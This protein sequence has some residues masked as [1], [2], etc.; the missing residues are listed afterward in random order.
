MAARNGALA[1]LIDVTAG[2]GEAG[3]AQGAIAEI[4]T[5]ENP[6]L[7][8]MTWK[9]GNLLTGERT[10]VRT[11]KPGVAWRRYNQ[12]VPVS[13]GTAGSIDEGAAQLAATSQMDRS[14]AILGGNPARARMSFAKP[15]FEAMNDEA[16]LKLFY[17]NATFESK[18]FTGLTPRFNSLS[19]PTASQ[20]L[21]CLGTGTDNRSM[22]LID[23]DEE[24]ITGIY[25]KGTKA[26]LLHMDST[27]N[28][29]SGPDGYPIGD[30]TPDASGNQYLAYT[31]FFQ[32]DLG[33]AVKDPRHVVRA[34]NIDFSLMAKD[35]STGADLEDILVQMFHRANRIGPNAAF[36]VPKPVG[37]ML[38]RQALSDS[39]NARG[40]IGFDEIG[41]RKVP[42]ALGVPIRSV[43]ALNVDE[44]RVV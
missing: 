40:I 11:G 14:L 20:I 4:L 19:G 37:A 5:K 30:L 16:S 26:G 6:I 22:W 27:A 13:K 39:R 43:D 3:E 29:V 42:S 32:W 25:P 41:G 7:E 44:A 18:E 34:A 21:D 23:W 31:D 1:T 35:R 28:R 36:Y 8:D 15:F 17:G 38:H 2:Y 9:E 24:A 10:W 33:L 12:G